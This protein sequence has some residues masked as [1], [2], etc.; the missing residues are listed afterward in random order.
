MGNVRSPDWPREGQQEAA[1]P[2]EACMAK[3]RWQWH[4]SLGWAA[5]ALLWPSASPWHPL[6]TL[7]TGETE[8]THRSVVLLKGTGLQCGHS[9]WALGGE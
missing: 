4:L 8:G 7:C 3:P 6:A 2:W 1:V 5:G 9:S